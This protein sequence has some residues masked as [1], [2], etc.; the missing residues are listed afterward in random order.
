MSFGISEYDA[1]TPE[2]KKAVTALA[3]AVGIKITECKEFVILDEGINFHMLTFSGGQPT[4]GGWMHTI[5]VP[6]K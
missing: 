2:G 1:L 4:P 5:S 6:F 3:A